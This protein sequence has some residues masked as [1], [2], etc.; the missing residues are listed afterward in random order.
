MSFTAAELHIFTSL[1]GDAIG[2]SMQAFRYVHFLRVWG[3]PVL[4][5]LAS[6]NSSGHLCTVLRSMY[7]SPQKRFNSRDC[8]HLA[9]QKIQAPCGYVYQWNSL[10]EPSRGL[11]V[12]HVPKKYANL[13]THQPCYFITFPTK[14]FHNMIKIKAA[15][16]YLV[17]L[18]CYY[19]GIQ[20]RRPA[21]GYP[22]ADRGEPSV[23]LPN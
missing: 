12:L 8:F 15:T 22:G 3:V 16:Y 9:G 19:E 6:S 13:T 5:H 11:L 18:R 23:L 10:L 14:Q 7:L 21:P 1:F 4:I 20:A 17:L 2:L